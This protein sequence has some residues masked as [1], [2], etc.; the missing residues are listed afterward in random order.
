MRHEAGISYLDFTPMVMIFGAVIV[1]M[2][3]VGMDTGEKTLYIMGGAVSDVP[4]LYL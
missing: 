4:V 1:S 3:Y 2:R